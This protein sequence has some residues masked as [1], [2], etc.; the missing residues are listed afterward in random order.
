[1]DKNMNKKFLV[2]QINAFELVPCKF[3]II[4]REYFP[5]AVNVSTKSRK[6]SNITN[7][8]AF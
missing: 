6:I 5:S 8:E 4:Q 7:R 1:M 3:E 2:F